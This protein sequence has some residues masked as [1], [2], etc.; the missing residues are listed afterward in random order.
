[1]SH[2]R[3]C[4]II[5]DD[6]DDQ[7]IFAMCLN[8]VDEDAECRAISDPVE[9]IEELEKEENYIP[10]YIFLDVN[11]PKINGI[12]CLRRLKTI[13]RLRHTKIFMYSTTSDGPALAQSR[14]LGAEDFIVKPPGTA[15]L[16]Q[17]LTAVFHMQQ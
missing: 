9:A 13:D 7:E 10:D 11:M 8:A 14:V 15:E 1:M 4:L 5:D 2:T 6:P 12:D 16:K 17:R 3:K